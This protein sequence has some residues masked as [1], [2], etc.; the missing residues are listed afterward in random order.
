VL[1]RCEFADPRSLS[2]KE[3]GDNKGSGEANFLGIKAS[4]GVKRTSL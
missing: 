2:G 3:A 1:S 4:L